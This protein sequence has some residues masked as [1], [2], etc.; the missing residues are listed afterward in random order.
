VA[1]NTKMPTDALA[2]AELMPKQ[3]DP[4]LPANN[5]RPAA[6]LPDNNHRGQ[7]T[8]GGTVVACFG[9][10]ANELHRRLALGRN[11][12]EVRQ[13]EPVP[14][15]GSASP[16]PAGSRHAT[17]AAGK[18][19]HPW[20]HAMIPSGPSREHRALAHLDARPKARQRGERRQRGC[21][22]RGAVYLGTSLL[23]LFAATVPA[24]AACTADLPS[25]SA[26][27]NQTV[28]AN[29][30]PFL[31]F[32]MYLE[33]DRQQARLPAGKRL[34][35]LKAA[36]LD[37]AARNVNLMVL[38]WCD[39]VYCR[40]LLDHAQSLGVRV[41][42]YDENVSGFEEIARR[43]KGHPA[44][45]GYFTSDDSNAGTTPGCHGPETARRHNGTR[46]HAAIRAIDPDHVA[47]IS[48]GASATVD[49]IERTRSGAVAKQDCAEI[50]G[51]QTYPVYG[52][53][54]YREPLRN[55]VRFGRA[56][57]SL[58]NRYDQAYLHNLQTFRH[59][60]WAGDPSAVPTP[61]E[62][63]NM[64]YQAIVAGAQGLVSFTYGMEGWQ[65]AD[66]PALWTAVGELGAEIRQ[67]GEDGFARNGRRAMGLPTGDAAIVAGLLTA[68]NDPGRKLVIV[69]NTQPTTRQFSV[70]L[71]A[72]IPDGSRASLLFNSLTQRRPFDVAT[73]GRRLAGTIAGTDVMVF[74]LACPSCGG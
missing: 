47:Y 34:K 63:R 68:A 14:A 23:L 19:G 49:L 22:W 43:F 58:A 33:L 8:A 39:F 16:A 1:A 20:D 28:L 72:M 10:V 73:Q 71:P 55:V 30:R 51:T 66:H 31:P 64:A 69:V 9:R 53:T 25:C 37:M 60:D 52:D 70:S 5:T 54:G 27:T 59:F 56:S 74:S 40:D 45:F 11:P 26:A 15:A 24:A 50:I 6:S 65:I 35:I 67:L 18:P 2:P 62:A 44:F 61:A 41:M 12:G 17:A 13:G 36:V 42:L 38:Y 48:L 3:D 21:L 7:H 4:L 46:I 29:G 32:G 57:R